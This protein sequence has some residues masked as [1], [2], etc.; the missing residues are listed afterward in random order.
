M[1]AFESFS[2]V[3]NSR[4]VFLIVLFCLSPRICPQGERLFRNE[5]NKMR[6][7]KYLKVT[8]LGVLS[9]FL[10]LES[11]AQDENNPW[12]ISVGLNSVDNRIGKSVSSAVEDY[13]GLNDQNTLLA[14]TTFSAN[15]YLK[16]GFS[17]G[18]D[19]SINEIEEG[20]GRENS[21]DFFFAIGANLRYDV[22]ELVGETGWFDPFVSLKANFTSIEEDDDYRVG[23]G[24]GFHTWFNEKIGLTFESSYNHNFDETGNDYF[25]HSLGVSFRFGEKDSDGDGVSDPK[26]VCPDEAGLP[27]FNGCPDSDGDGV[28]NAD[29]ACPNAAGSIDMEGCPDSDGDGVVDAN[30]ACPNS[31]G[32]KRHG[33]CPDSDGDG[34]LDKDDLCIRE[35]GPLDN[36]GCPYSDKNSPDID[37][38]GDGIMDKDDACIDEAG[39]KAKKVCPE[40]L[41]DGSKELGD[42]SKT[43]NF[44]FGTAKLRPEATKHLNGVVAV[45]NE[46]P[47][48]K[49]NLL[50]YADDVGLEA[51]NLRLSKNRAIAVKEYLVQKGVDSNRLKIKGHGEQYPIASNQTAEGREANRRVEIVIVK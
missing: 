19:V 49:F 35:A 6:S 5:G 28:V 14:I 25:Q 1:L 33:G 12:L 43:V 36:R 50:G 42:F 21:E 17:A 45:L 30:D 47:T 24:Y 38:D 44:D 26:D 46:F 13:F 9:M 7:M 41:S 4:S 34:V 39:T 2:L 11:N 15:R 32:S 29:D 3:K 27:K 48:V 20:F 31:V 40:L 23:L 22:N 8:L 37:T 16:N 51:Y 18:V 10:C